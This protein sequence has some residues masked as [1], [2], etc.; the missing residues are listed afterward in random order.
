MPPTALPAT[1][2]SKAAVSA[3]YFKVNV[4][5]ATC[6]GDMTARRNPRQVSK[7]LI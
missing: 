2:L 5:P 4:R 6:L 7:R 1:L 3:R